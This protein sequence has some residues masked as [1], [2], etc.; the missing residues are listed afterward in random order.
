MVDLPTGLYEHLVTDRLSKD[1]AAVPDLVQLGTLD[2]VDAQEALT[3]HIAGLASRALR[4][5]G[6]GDSAAVS[7]QVELANR[8]VA[9]IGDLAPEAAT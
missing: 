6:G 9:A 3:R 7:R 4:T 1:L 2:P 8:I 5:A